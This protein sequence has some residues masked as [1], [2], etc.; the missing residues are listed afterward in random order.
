MAGGEQAALLRCSSKGGAV[1]LQLAPLGAA[2]GGVV[3]DARARWVVCWS[4]SEGERREGA[5]RCGEGE[6]GPAVE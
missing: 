2:R 6:R 5:A 4:V 3:N 1:L